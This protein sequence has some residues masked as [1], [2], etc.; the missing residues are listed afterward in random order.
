M[1][2]CDQILTDEYP[3]L[4][5]NDFT[6]S[7]YITEEFIDQ[8]S[9]AEEANIHQ[10]SSSPK[11]PPPPSV[12]PSP[13][14]TQNVIP[15]KSIATEKRKR[16]RSKKDFIEVQKSKHLLLS[17]ACTPKCSLTCTNRI[18]EEK[19]IELHEEFWCSEY[20][21]RKMWNAKHVD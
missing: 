17:A 15:H 3:A 4:D 6:K 10:T 2:Q 1:K 21:L 11:S 20:D 18:D 16:P 14:P 8:L 12:P 9:P 7:N 5:I 19:R 13:P